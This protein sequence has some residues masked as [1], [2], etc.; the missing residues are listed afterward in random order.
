MAGNEARFIESF[1]REFYKVNRNWFFYK[2]PD[3]DR[4]G[5]K[6]FDVIINT[7][8]VH[9]LEFKWIEKNR[10]SFKVDALFRIH[11]LRNLAKL[12]DLEE[13]QCSW[14]I[15]KK[16]YDIFLFNIDQLIDKGQIFLD[17]HTKLSVK[18]VILT[19]CNNFKI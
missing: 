17:N 6:P 7:G 14:G 12:Q 11:Q 4:T 5:L 13:R 10:K 19:L 18:E 1:K 16:G 15:I 8:Q 3:A 2:I 9:Y